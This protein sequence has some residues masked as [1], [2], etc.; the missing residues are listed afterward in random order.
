MTSENWDELWSHCLSKHCVRLRFATS[1]I[2]RALTLQLS[3]GGKC[4]APVTPVVC[5]TYNF[6][7]DKFLF[8]A[9]LA[10]RKNALKLK[11]SAVCF[12]SFSDANYFTV[13]GKDWRSIPRL[14]QCVVAQPI[15][16]ARHTLFLLRTNGRFQFH[17]LSRQ[18][19]LQVAGTSRGRGDRPPN[20]WNRFG[21][22]FMPIT[23]ILLS[24][25]S[26][27]RDHRWNSARRRPGKYLVCCHAVCCIWWLLVN[28]THHT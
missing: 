10:R 23:S 2:E 19:S 27:L 12:L 9:L 25:L 28:H 18:I 7:A 5:A 8:Y 21:C 22:D 4:R 13:L 15:R 24:S 26:I 6:F 16:R 14:R 3:K 17:R 20:K 1:T 11:V